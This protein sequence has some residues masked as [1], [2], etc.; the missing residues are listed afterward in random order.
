MRLDGVL[1]FF[2][3]SCEDFSRAIRYA[4][5]FAI[6]TACS[7][8]RG[9][10]LPIIPSR[11]QSRRISATISPWLIVFLIGMVYNPLTNN[12][13]DVLYHRAKFGVDAMYIFENAGGFISQRYQNDGF[14][15]HIFLPKQIFQKRNECA[16]CHHADFSQHAGNPGRTIKLS[17]FDGPH[18]ASYHIERHSPYEYQEILL[19]DGVCEQ[20]LCRT[21]DKTVKCLHCFPRL[22]I[23]GLDKLALNWV[24]YR[25]R[26]RG[27]WV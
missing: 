20:F 10:I 24:N 6:S 19:R 4:M 11:F 16:S 25:S 26:K 9:L 22:G 2:S 7:I 12:F 27:W 15:K 1:R 13:A 23:V 8:L 17:V 3:R 21:N 18:N 5:A 14:C